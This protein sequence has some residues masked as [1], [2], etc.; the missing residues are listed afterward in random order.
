[1]N[2]TT[3]PTPQVPTGLK[4]E[5]VQLAPAAGKLKAERVQL[6]LRDL[7]A[8]RFAQGAQVIARTWEL[9]DGLQVARLLRYVADLAAGGAALPE[10]HIGPG[11]VTFALPTVGGSWLEAESFEMALALESQ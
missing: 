2:A 8:W 4:A 5:R 3:T 9:P 1:M 11:E 7:P 10:V 6:A